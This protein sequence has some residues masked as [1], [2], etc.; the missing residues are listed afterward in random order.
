MWA[1]PDEKTFAP[2]LNPAN[3]TSGGNDGEEQFMNSIEAPAVGAYRDATERGV[4]A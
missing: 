3:R 1:A 2:R 4:N